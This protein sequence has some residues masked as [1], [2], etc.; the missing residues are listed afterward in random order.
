M[1]ANQPTGAGARV[2][3]V[4]L[5]SG[6]LAMPCWIEPPIVHA[7]NLPLTVKVTVGPQDPKVAKKNWGVKW[8]LK[9]EIL[10]L[11]SA[12]QGFIWH[13]QWRI[14]GLQY[15]ARWQ[16]PWGKPPANSGYAG[17]YYN[18]GDCAASLEACPM[19]NG[20]WRILWSVHALTFTGPNGEPV[21]TWSGDGS[22]ATTF[23]VGAIVSVDSQPPDNEAHE[24]G[25]IPGY[26]MFRRQDGDLSQPLT[27]YYETNGTATPAADYTP[28]PGNVT[29]QPNETEVRVPLVPVDDGVFEPDEYVTVTLIEDPNGLNAYAIALPG[30]ATITIKDKRIVKEPDFGD[31]PPGG[32]WSYGYYENPTDPPHPDTFI[33]FPKY[34]VPQQYYPGQPA[35]KC[36]FILEG[37]N[38]Y[39]T[40][41]WNGGGHPNGTVA[42]GGRKQVLHW[43][44]RRWKSNLT[45]KI[46]VTGVVAK[47]DSGGNGV[48]T[49]IYIEG[50]KVWTK[51][52]E[53]NETA[54]SSY[55]V[56]AAIYN[57]Q[58]L[59][60]VIDPI[61]TNEANDSTKFTGQIEILG[62][63]LGDPVQ[64]LIV[65]DEGQ[66]GVTGDMVPSNKANGEKHYVSPKKAASHVVLKAQL[67]QGQTMDNYKWD[68]AAPLAN[69]PDKSQ[70]S[71][72]AAGKFVVKLLKKAD[73][74]EV[75]RLNVWIVWASMQRKKV[76]DI[77]PVLVAMTPKDPQTFGALGPGTA[78][79]S[80]WEFR[81]TIAPPEIWDAN[82][83]IPD[84]TGAAT[85]P[86]PGAN[87]KH[88]IDGT[89]LKD[90]ATKR[91]D[92]SRQIRVGIKSPT[93]PT[94]AYSA[95]AKGAIFDGLPSPKRLAEDYPVDE[96][97]GNDD[98][99][100]ADAINPDP[101]AD[102]ENNPYS[103]A[104]PVPDSKPP[105]NLPKGQLAAIDGPVIPII[106][107][108]PKSGAVDDTVEFH[109]H[110]RDF[111]RLQIGTNQSLHN[112]RNWYRISDFKEGE[113]RHVAA[114]IR[115]IPGWGRLNPTTVSDAT[116]DGW[117]FGPN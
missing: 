112:Y 29:F 85:A 80:S 30:D 57:G 2:G 3:C 20:Y 62:P 117:Q 92:M 18:Q 46:K 99:S 55:E 24:A 68:G 94:G 100:V 66:R 101:T 83:D 16:D 53:A 70:V 88:I 61:G 11:P 76:T 26:Y 116:N 4:L 96:A 58:R 10:N 74:T 106:S 48:N 102:E 86:V 19:L 91:W 56:I 105:E 84:L 107:N 15:K 45:A 42:G 47:L 50:Q 65:P 73:N 54:E 79:G 98:P 14:E 40:R 72:D 7:A 110:F 28:L 13:M 64:G 27:V 93:V 23:S 33:K 9:G 38:G 71:R 63:E 114:L 34:E 49:H 67:P 69:A 82:A 21:G 87:R 95:S 60:W 113:W 35:G 59:D 109:V 36:W 97:E 12:A 90:G 43:S 108:H 17:F 6:I 52:L 1:R 115:R 5:A 89:T 78:V 25:Q 75:A 22:G 81:A 31:Q 77:T 41:W 51:K 39:W 32:D 103:D 37:A 8:Q 104:E 111:V 44:V